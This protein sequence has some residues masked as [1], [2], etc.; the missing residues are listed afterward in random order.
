MIELSLIS[1]FLVGLLGGGHCVGMCG[2]IVGAVSMHLPQSKSKVPFLLSYNAGRILSYTLAGVIA[3]LVGAS[4]FFLHHILPI[5]HV[6]YGISSLMLIALGLYLADI[7][8]GVT[9]LEGAGK[10][11]WKTLQPFSKRYIPV[12]NIKQ[13]FFLGSLWGWLPCGLVYSVLIAAIA[14]GSAINGGLLMLAFGLG[15]LPTLLTMGM[16]AVRL[17]TVL[18]NIWVRRASGLLV[19]GFGL[20]GLLRL[21]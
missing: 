5:Q 14:T 15:T 18:Q 8:H 4:S 3:G 6:L 9:Y 11:I 17:K 1:A 16:A 7:W 21:I 19:L 10:G 12:Q 2:G 20:V 13:A